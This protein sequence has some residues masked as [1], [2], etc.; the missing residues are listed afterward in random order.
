M[1]SLKTKGS[2]GGP[3]STNSLSDGAALDVSDFNPARERMGLPIGRNMMTSAAIACLLLTCSPSTVFG[4][5]GSIVI[6]AIESVQF[7]R[8]DS[9]ILVEGSEIIPLWAY[10][11]TSPTIAGIILMVGV[12]ATF[13]HVY[14]RSPFRVTAHA[15]LQIAAAF[16]NGLF[17][18]FTCYFFLAATA[19]SSGSAAQ[20]TTK[21][22]SLS[23][24][25]TYAMP[26][27]AVILLS[28]RPGCFSSYKQPTEPCSY[29]RYAHRV[30]LS[31]NYRECN[32]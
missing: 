1:S 24:A 18:A 27:S 15:V 31:N 25:V 6:N 13:A 30:L 3:T 12:G 26:P 20:A 11:N 17:D 9:H 14:P 5:V 19:A 28:N 2:F 7:A 23:A 29:H 16:S 8:F 21:Y 10:G 4:S 22:G 32:A